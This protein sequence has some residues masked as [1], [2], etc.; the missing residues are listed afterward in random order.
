MRQLESF[1]ALWETVESVSW[2]QKKASAEWNLLVL[3]SI[4][5]NRQSIVA[6]NVLLSSIL[7][8]FISYCVDSMYSQ[9]LIMSVKVIMAML[10]E[11]SFGFQFGTCEF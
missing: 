10:D 2:A 9:Y 5:N 4:D 1:C 7:V 11:D 8:I 6:I 3:V